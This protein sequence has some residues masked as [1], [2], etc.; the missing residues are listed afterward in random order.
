MPHLKALPRLIG[1]LVLASLLGCDAPSQHPVDA[2]EA[3]TPAA[4]GTDRL[5]QP[6]A[7]PHIRFPADAGH[8]DV[9]KPPYNAD[10]TGVADSTAAIQQAI[11]DCTKRG[12]A[13]F[14]DRRIVYFPNGT[15]RLTAGLAYRNGRPDGHSSE[16]GGPCLIG[17]SRDGVIL[18]LDDKLQAFQDAQS[19]VPVISTIEAG[20]WGNVAFMLTLMN[21]TIDIGA[22][23]PG[24][25]GIR[26]IAHNQGSVR[27]ITIRSSDPARAGHAGI[28]MA[29]ASIPGPDL[30]KHVRIE[31]FDY[32][33]RIA[34]P[35]YAMTIEALHLAGQRIAGI[36]NHEHSLTIRRLHSTNSVPAIINDQ[37]DGLVVCVDSLLIAD[38]DASMA[39]INRGH[40]MLRNVTVEGYAGALEHAGEAVDL[41][42]GD[43]HASRRTIALW[44]SSALDTGQARPLRPALPVEDTPAIA[45]DDPATWVNVQSF[46]KD[47]QSETADDNWNDDSIAIQA[48][49]DSMTGKQH[50]LYFPPGSY[51]VARTIVLRGN[52]RRVCGLWSRV[53]TTPRIEQAEEPMFLVPEDRTEPLHI[54][55]FNFPPQPRRRANAFL[56][57]RSP[58]DLVLRNV[59][60]GHGKAYVNR[61][62]TGR[63]FLEDVCALAHH[64]YAKHTGDTAME[65]L[66]QANP[67][68]DFGNQTVWARQLDPEQYGTMLQ[69]D[70]GRL[71]VLGIKTEMPGIV[72]DARNGAIVD[73]LGGTIM[74]VESPVTPTPAIRVENAHVQ[75][76]VA[77]YVGTMRQGTMLVPRGTYDLFIEDVSADETRTYGK[78][79]LTARHGGRA[80]VIPWAQF[81]PVE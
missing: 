77:E 76:S 36:H 26:Y 12:A 73:L 11:D 52:V 28:D 15:Y 74:P 10:P 56:E 55:M 41:S 68:F 66:P 3:A 13:A 24:A 65:A 40:M 72:L 70:G 63:L 43:E 48:A 45:W 21:F 38:R 8:V 78:N 39:V 35:H 23:N 80:V 16:G 67:Q 64:Y 51:K 14:A 69:T 50:T 34:S 57:N 2:T 71:W 9:T 6:A 58:H 49:I 5:W 37:A 42:R 20:K 4:E 79:E 31:G 19:P 44:S 47:P 1:C 22:G 60:V 27:D 62:S 81:E 32:G 18:K 54:D 53:G 30:I 46:M 25:S 33:I 29:T 61:G 7:S 75:L 17:E 59:Y